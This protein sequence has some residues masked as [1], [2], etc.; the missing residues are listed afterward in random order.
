[1]NKK[2]IFAGLMFLVFA[3]AL[4]SFACL[5]IVEAGHNCVGEDCPVCYQLS[6]CESAVKY[7]FV[8]AVLAMLFA[9]L[10]LFALSFSDCIL[11]LRNC[12]SLVFLKV[13][14]SD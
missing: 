8:G 3:I 13:K 1:M 4:L 9:A 7:S 12:I 14:L 2:R 10:R 5:V 11:Q 6:I